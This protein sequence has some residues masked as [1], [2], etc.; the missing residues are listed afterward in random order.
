MVTGARKP[1]FFL[2]EIKYLEKA[3]QDKFRAVHFYTQA[4]IEFSNP[5]IISGRIAPEKVL[6][7]LNLDGKADITLHFICGPAGLKQSIKDTLQKFG[8]NEANIFSEDFEVIKN[9]QDFEDIITQEVS[10]VIN[11]QL[12]RVE[13]T[14][15]KSILDAGLDAGLELLYSCQTGDCM[16]CKA[17]LVQGKVKMLDVKKLLS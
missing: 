6:E 12:N 10:L 3:Y 1:L 17:E 8:I 11:D 5:Y 2:N 14:K 15:G 16:L 9:P 13:V 7:V 4:V